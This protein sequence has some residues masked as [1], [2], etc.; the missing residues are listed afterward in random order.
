MLINSSGKCSVISVKGGCALFCSQE[1]SVS[2]FDYYTLRE[3][4]GGN[5]SLKDDFIASPWG[6]ALTLK[7]TSGY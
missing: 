4:W 7:G 2:P 3:R 1:G 5:V 6:I